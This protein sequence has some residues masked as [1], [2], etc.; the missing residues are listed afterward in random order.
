M[1]NDNPHKDL[2]NDADGGDDDNDDEDG[3]CSEIWINN[4]ILWQ[5]CSLNYYFMAHYV[6][7]FILK[8]TTVPWYNHNQ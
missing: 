6:L 1:A 4:I 7:A 5:V 3:D 8:K 2:M